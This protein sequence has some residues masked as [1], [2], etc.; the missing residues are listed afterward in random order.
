MELSDRQAVICKMMAEQGMTDPEAIYTEIR[1]RWEGTSLDDVRT[2][3]LVA[4]NESRQWA[5]AMASTVWP[6]ITKRIIDKRMSRLNKMYKVLDELLEAGPQSAGVAARLAKIIGDDEI[7]LLQL[8]EHGP[9][10]DTVERA[11]TA[12]TTNIPDG[13]TP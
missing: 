10:A 9:V 5:R 3:M 12:V 7:K 11:L 4:A 6:A 2:E 13:D 1:K 8:V